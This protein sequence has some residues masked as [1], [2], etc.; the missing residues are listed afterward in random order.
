MSEALA[1]RVPPRRD[2]TAT[3]RG[4]LEAA[5]ELVSERGP[6]ALTMSDVAHRASVNRVTLYQHFRTRED[7][8]GA[9]TERVSEEVT[10]LLM[11]AAA[12][13]Q[14]VEFMLEYLLD[15]PEVGRLWIYGILSEI[16]VANPA[17]WERYQHSIERFAASDAAAPDIDAEM[18]AHV[19]HSAV[20]LWSV[21]ARSRIADPEERREQTRRYA[22]ELNRLLRHGAVRRDAI[23]EQTAQGTRKEE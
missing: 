19:L 5:R 8:L 9:V 22:R 6:D 20:L 13:D 23:P 17:S 18:L 15:H 12:P 1:Q 16:P 2:P 10:G 7:L 4:I 3:R 21:R 14:R 11:T